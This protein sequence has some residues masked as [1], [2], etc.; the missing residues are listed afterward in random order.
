[1]P[2]APKPACPVCRRV[3]CT[4]PSHRAKPRGERKLARPEYGTSAERKRRHDTVAAFMAEHGFLLSDG[5]TTAA[6]CPE[7]R[8]VRVRFIADHVVPIAEGGTEDGELGIHCARCSGRQGAA[9]ANRKRRGR[10]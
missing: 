3:R 4:D 2:W 8:E 9:I 1:V 6:R 7:C 5:K 10:G